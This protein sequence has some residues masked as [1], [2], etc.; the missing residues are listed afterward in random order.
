[1]KRP[2]PCA[3]C[4]EIRDNP[5]LFPRHLVHPV[6]GTPGLWDIHCEAICLLC[7]TRWRHDRGGGRPEIVD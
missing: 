6:D 7:G 5:R 1:M 4:I 3:V 2:R